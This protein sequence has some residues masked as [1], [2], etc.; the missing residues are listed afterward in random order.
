MTSIAIREDSQTAAAVTAPSDLQQWAQSARE[1][2][3]VAV[4]L[5]KTPFVPASLRDRDDSVTV[6]NITAAI[7]TGQE[8]GL[9]PMAALRALDVIQGTPAFRAITLRA[10]VLSRGHDLWLAEST[11]TRAIVRGKR[12]GS[13]EVQES[14]WT[15]DRARGLSLLGKSNWKS[16]PGAMLVARA[17]AECARLV[18][19]DVIMGVAYSTEE[20]LDGASDTASP[21]V[22]AEQGE[23]K[24]TARRRTAPA[25]ARFERQP[26]EQAEPAPEPEPDFEPSG[27]DE[28][29]P[30][31]SNPPAAVEPITGA[32]QKM[33]HAL[34][35]ENGLGDRDAG[36]AFVNAELGRTPDDAITSTKHLTK[37]EASL[38]IDALNTLSDP[39]EYDDD[40]RHD[41]MLGGAE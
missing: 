29:H 23:P 18:A 1:A 6:G 21:T 32:Q 25:P 2:A 22:T 16:Q 3:S 4:S 34:L 31:T 36:L 17:T 28:F 14:V 33:L 39:P 27:M 9:Q 15:L 20:L 41:G 13:T 37:A 12:A 24:R 7:L 11:E 10:L 8:V 30:D 35:N 38:V 5:A 19:P 26:V 40:G